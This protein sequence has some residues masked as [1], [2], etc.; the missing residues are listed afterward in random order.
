MHP[1]D[2]VGH[3]EYAP[4]RKSDQ[5]G[6]PDPFDVTRLPCVGA[7]LAWYHGVSDAP[8]GCAS[9]GYTSVPDI[10]NHAAEVSPAG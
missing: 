1:S 10:V 3:P 9:V 8:L 5:V 2:A 7:Y 4:G 6:R